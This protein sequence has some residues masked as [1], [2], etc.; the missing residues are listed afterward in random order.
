MT[1]STDPYGQSDSANGNFYG[2]KA[3]LQ[4]MIDKA[5]KEL[6]RLELLLH[7]QPEIIN[8]ATRAAVYRELVADLRQQAGEAGYY[9]AYEQAGMKEAAERFTAWA[10]YLS[11]YGWASKYTIEGEP[12]ILTL[13]IKVD[14]A[15]IQGGAQA[16]IKLMSK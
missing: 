5:K 4:H 7:A 6:A 1:K 9:A 2:F 3:N 15:Y 11:K 10:D 14:E 16:V 12:R 8:D 13:E